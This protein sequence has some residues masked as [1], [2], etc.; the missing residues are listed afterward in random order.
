M[1]TCIQSATMPRNGLQEGKV[2]TVLTTH[3]MEECEAL[4]SRIGILHEGRL[5]CLGSLSRLKAT[6][7]DAFILEASALSLLIP[8]QPGE[9]IR[10]W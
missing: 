8:S 1:W 3:S 2:T 9:Y 10:P 4:C 7:A 6:Y 5:L